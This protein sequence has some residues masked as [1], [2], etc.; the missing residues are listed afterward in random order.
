MNWQWPK[1]L[2]FVTISGCAS[3][4]DYHFQQ[5]NE[6][7]AKVAWREVKG[8][9]SEAE[10]TVTSPTAFR[11]ATSMHRAVETERR[12]QSLQTVIGA[13][14]SRVMRGWSASISGT[15]VLPEGPMRLARKALITGI[16]FPLEFA[17]LT[18]DCRPREPRE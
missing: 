10:Q 5:A 18:D 15:V 13:L 17:A 1:V 12:R 9:L 7:R 2:F 6:R 11:R 14:G 8:C 4:S 16:T 3:I